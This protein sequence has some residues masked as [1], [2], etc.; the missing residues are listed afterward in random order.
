ML[1]VNYNTKNTNTSVLVYNLA[2]TIVLQDELEPKQMEHAIQLNDL[3]H[4]S[5]II[6]LSNDSFV[7]RQQFVKR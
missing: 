6:E 7:A 2:G 3:Q 5:Y 4:G 1:N